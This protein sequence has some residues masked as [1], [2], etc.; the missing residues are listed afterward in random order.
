MIMRVNLLAPAFR[1]AR[2]CWRLPSIR[3]HGF[4][5][6]KSTWPQ[7]HNPKRERGTNLRRF[8][9]G[10]SMFLASASGYYQPQCASTRLMAKSP[11]LTRTGCL[12]QQPAGGGP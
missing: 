11:T 6:A 4:D 10:C 12:C 9:D 1:L 3:D 8:H 5:D 2:R 7:H